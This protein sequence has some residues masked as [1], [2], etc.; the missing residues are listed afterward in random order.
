MTMPT[1]KSILL[2]VLLLSVFPG[3]F[4]VSSGERG[5]EAGGENSEIPDLAGVWALQW[6]NLGGSCGP[7]GGYKIMAA[8]FIQSGRTLNILL[9]VD[10]N[11]AFDDTAFIDGEISSNGEL[12]LLSGTYF[13]D[14]VEIGLSGS[15]Q[16]MTFGYLA[17]ALFRTS[18]GSCQEE[19]SAVCLWTANPPVYDFTG[20]WDFDNFVT[21]VNGDCSL[22]AGATSAEVWT[23]D[24]IDLGLTPGLFRVSTDSG[25]QFIGV[26][27]SSQVTLGRRYLSGIEVF[28]WQYTSLNFDGWG[29]TSGNGRL[30]GQV[31]GQV[32]GF[33]ECTFGMDVDGSRL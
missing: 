8:K 14:D 17:G 23:I 7:G 19:L 29:G 28:T 2:S 5:S 16:Y 31:M 24:H 32:D 11:N 1:R 21:W 6:E 13:A 10:G 12:I 20:S 22:S 30:F 26:L 18:D 3:C 4:Y 25:E 33:A 27:N 9:D 15:F